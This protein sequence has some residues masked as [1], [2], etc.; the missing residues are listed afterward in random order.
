MNDVALAIAGALPWVVAPLIVALRARASRSLDESPTEPPPDAPLV[1]VIIPAR[2]E[3]RSIAHCVRSVLATTY[4]RVEVIVVDDHSTDGTGDL[5][6]AAAPADDHR[7]RVIVPPPLPDDWFGKQWACASG[8]R[9]ARGEVLCF[10]DADTRHAPDLLV[11]SVHAMRDHRADLFSVAG[12][13]ELGGFWERVIQP[14][15]FALLSARYGGTEHME[16]SPRAV[17]KIANGQC[18]FVRRE[19]YEALGGHGIVKDKVAED[20]ALAQRV[21]AAGRRVGLAVGLEQLSTRMYTSLGELVRGWGKNVY[22]GGREAMRGGRLGRALF[23]VLLPAGPLFSLVPLLV[24]LLGVAGLVP[25]GAM[26]WGA[27]ATGA[28]TAWWTMAYLAIG[29]S[30]LYALAWPLGAA[31]LLWIML[32]AIARGDRVT[33][34]GRR[35]RS[36]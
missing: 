4:P 11:R 28:I 24:L 17:D 9:E 33:W 13:Q 26:L 14:Q 21:F 12:R 27:L 18:L 6:R 23:P 10:A 30:P 15:V 32:T 35:Y 20:L 5:A 19:A 7:L 3:A 1:S 8:A 31:V 34:K 29:E 16:R 2:N 22:A 25:S 36:R